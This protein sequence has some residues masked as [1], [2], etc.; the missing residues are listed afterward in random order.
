M[1]VEQAIQKSS[2]LQRSA[3]IRNI[4]LLRSSIVRLKRCY[5]HCAPTERKQRFAIRNE[6]HMGLVEPS[7]VAYEIQRRYD[8]TFAI[9]YE[10]F[11]DKYWQCVNHLSR[12]SA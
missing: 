9:D 6:S 12:G 3:T 5:K 4:P 10:I 8:G 1:F 7:K 2:A 11:K